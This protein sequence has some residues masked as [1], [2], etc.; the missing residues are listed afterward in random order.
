MPVAL[1]ATQDWIPLSYRANLRLAAS[2][3]NRTVSSTM[4][5]CY[6][7][8][9]NVRVM[10]KSAATTVALSAIVHAVLQGRPPG[11]RSFKAA[12]A[13][14]RLM[15]ALC[16]AG[17]S[18]PRWSHALHAFCARRSHRRMAI[19]GSYNSPLNIAVCTRQGCDS[20]HHS[21]TQPAAPFSPCTSDLNT[22]CRTHISIDSSLLAAT[23]RN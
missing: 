10:G 5:V 14:S 17:G 4:L 23:C 13:H 16:R 11:R 8:K 15:Q 7:S 3:L 21:I 19:G 9:H 22:H 12:A 20:V 18:P 6:R 2:A 1:T